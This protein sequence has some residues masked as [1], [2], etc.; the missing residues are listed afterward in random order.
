[1]T[2]A[3]LLAGRFETSDT[4]SALLEQFVNVSNVGIDWSAADF[5]LTR[6]EVTIKAK[7][8]Y[9]AFDRYQNHHGQRLAVYTSSLYNVASGKIYAIDLLPGDLVMYT[10]YGPKLDM[11]RNYIVKAFTSTDTIGDTVEYIASKIPVASTNYDNIVAN[12]T[13]ID[14]WNPEF[15]TGSYPAD[16]LSE[17]IDMSD[18]SNRV[19]DVRMIDQPL[20]ATALRQYDLHYGYRDTSASADWIVERKDI[21]LNMSRNIEAFANIVRVWYGLITG[22]ST[23]VTSITMTDISADFVGDGVLPGDTLTNLTKVG[24]LVPA[25]A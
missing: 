21:Q 5:G 2:G 24:V 19:Y 11:E 14:G 15:P 10:A 23:S 18:S 17:L 16:A 13:T 25:F 6:I 3:K 8:N 12:T 9:D 22:S 4:S 7:N 1:M 20:A